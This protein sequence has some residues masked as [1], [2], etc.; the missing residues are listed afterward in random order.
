M[1]AMYGVAQARAVGDFEARNQTPGRRR[2]WEPLCKGPRREHPLLA[3]V[4]CGK[5]CPCQQRQDKPRRRRFDRNGGKTLDEG[6]KTAGGEGD[7]RTDRIPGWYTSLRNTICGGEGKLFLVF[8]FR[9]FYLT[10]NEERTWGSEEVAKKFYQKLVTGRS[11]YKPTRTG[12]DPLISRVSFVHE[13]LQGVRQVVG[14][15]ETA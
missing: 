12:E 11:D 13:P 10:G 4:E 6:D 14:T 5:L 8:A 1:E 2:A 7:D 3:A 15:H 9:R